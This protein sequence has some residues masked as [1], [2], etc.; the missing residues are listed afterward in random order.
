MYIVYW[1]YATKMLSHTTFKKNKNRKN[2]LMCVSYLY[3]GTAELAL[4]WSCVCVCI[5]VLYGWESCAKMHKYISLT[6]NEEKRRVGKKKPHI[7]HKMRQ[8]TQFY[9]VWNICHQFVTMQNILVS[10]T[11]GIFS[12]SPL[13]RKYAKC[14]VCGGKSWMWRA[15]VLLLRLHK[16]TLVNSAN[17]TTF[18]INKKKNHIKKSKEPL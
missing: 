16:M 10:K 15:N 4:P 13:L 3:I 8:S 12:L 17:A 1:L 2:L 9:F 18:W 5:C 11:N 14:I 7:R 6:S